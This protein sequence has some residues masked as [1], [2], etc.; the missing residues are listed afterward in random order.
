MLHH[1]TTPAHTSLLICEFLAKHETTVIP[2]LPYSPDLAPAD[3]FVPEV[4]IYSER[5]PISDD[6][7]DRRNVAMGP[8][9]CPTKRV[10]GHVPEL[11]KMGAVYKQWRGV[12]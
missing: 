8:M 12:L 5:S 7:R 9:Y 10:L 11:E 4:E 1:S 2:E 3:F 6:R